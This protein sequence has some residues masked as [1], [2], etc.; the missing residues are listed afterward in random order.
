MRTDTACVVMPTFN[1]R[2]NINGTVRDVLAC[3]PSVEV[4]VVDDASPDG[5]GELAD[6]LAA[7]TG[8]VHVLHRSAKMGLG[9][10]YIAGFSYAL[11]HGYGLVCEMDMDGS[12]R[13]QDLARM[14]A[15]ITGD[16]GIDLV[17]G[18]R[19]ITGGATPNW[20]WYRDM[21]SRAG[22]W[23]AR[24]MLGLH[25]R[26]MTA[27]FRVYRASMLQSLD[28]RGEQSNGY[29]FQIDMTRRV[30]AAGGRIVEVPITFP[31][32]V[33]GVSKMSLAIVVEAMAK[34]TMW[35]ISRWLHRGPV[36]R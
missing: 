16:R 26:D 7:R 17:V 18:S 9:P 21:I 1:E 8:R 32:R 22:S 28:L 34:V 25:V 33:R 6:A 29:V 20:P 24:A 19:R 35:G 2:E 15:T 36:T 3:N 23:Y 13:A 27:G 11:Q 4:L 5:T 10:A 14:I 30:A 12:H 31:E